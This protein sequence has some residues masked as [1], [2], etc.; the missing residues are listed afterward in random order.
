[1]VFEN[2][3]NFA[4][5]LPGK[6][7]SLLASAGVKTRGLKDKR[8]EMCQVVEQQ[9][10]QIGRIFNLFGDCIF[11]QLLGIAEVVQIFAL[12]FYKGIRYVNMY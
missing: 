2:G 1:L 5:F 8:T 6:T 11:G 7:F 3:Q 10:D 4:S 12:L 9:G